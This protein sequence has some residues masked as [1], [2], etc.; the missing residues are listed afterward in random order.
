MAHTAKFFVAGI[1]KARALKE[2]LGDNKVEHSSERLFLPDTPDP[3]LLAPHTFERYLIER[4]RDEAH[5]FALSAHRRGR[6]N[7]V[8]KSKL[9]AIPGIGKK[10]A[11]ELLRHFGSM[12]SVREASASD[13][14]KVINVSL[15][16]AGHRD[17]EGAYIQIIYIKSPLSD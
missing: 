4:I 14:A 7:R 5:R 11:L 3:V 10:R 6:K 13:I 12:K 2:E 8:M 9:A 15:K 1:A 17:C 16:K